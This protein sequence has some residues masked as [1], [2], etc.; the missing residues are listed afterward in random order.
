ML[1]RF[2]PA[3]EL[4]KMLSRMA[5]MTVRMFTCRFRADNVTAGAFRSAKRMRALR[6]TSNDSVCVAL[7]RHAQTAT[8]TWPHWC[9]LLSHVEHDCATAGAGRRVPE[10]GL[11]SSNHPVFERCRYDYGHDDRGGRSSSGC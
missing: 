10:C 7:N 9:A 5:A 8:L 6:I 4:D 1:R 11:F 2:V 3:E